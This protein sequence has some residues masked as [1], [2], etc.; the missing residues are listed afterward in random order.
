VLLLTPHP[1][2]RN[3]LTDVESFRL[4]YMNTQT[5]YNCG[6]EKE[7]DAFAK[8]KR[9][10]NG[11]HRQCKECI[12]EYVR[13]HYRDNKKYY[14]ENAIK[15]KNKFRKEIAGLKESEPCF[16]CKRH[17]PS[18]V[19]HYDH[20]ENKLDNVSGLVNTN[21]HQKAY[22]E[23]KKCD[24]VCSNCHAIRTHNRKTSGR[25]ESNPRN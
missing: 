20:L 14:S 6:K 11:H 16:D 7:L 17:Y 3:N 24:L 19:M 18:Y 21:S 5:C 15:N 23:I 13:Q 2:N 4:Y 25:R 12:R 1:R 22:A 8:N 9:M 10:D